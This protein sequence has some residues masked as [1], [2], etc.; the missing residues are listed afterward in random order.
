[1]G[2]ELSFAWGLACFLRDQGRL[3]EKK[4][5][6]TLNVKGDKEGRIITF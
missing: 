3:V 2:Y 4:K 1:M 6:K 5:V